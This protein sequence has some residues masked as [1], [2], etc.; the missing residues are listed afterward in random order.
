MRRRR[1][2]RAPRREV[3]WSCRPLRGADKEN[4]ATMGGVGPARTRSP[5]HTLRHGGGCGRRAVHVAQSVAEEP[6]LGSNR[7]ARFLKVVLV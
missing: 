5:G 4:V 2:L 1:L 3:P 6:V 7:S